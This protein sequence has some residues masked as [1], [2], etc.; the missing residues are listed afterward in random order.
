MDGDQSRLACDELSRVEAAPT[1]VVNVVNYIAW[2]RTSASYIR[3]E[4]MS[5]AVESLPGAKKSLR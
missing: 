5:K 4:L 1:K 2:E 3:P